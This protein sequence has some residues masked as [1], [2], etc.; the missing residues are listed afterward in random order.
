M[1]CPAR[2]HYRSSS[3]LLPS[4]AIALGMKDLVHPGALPDNVGPTRP[5]HP[6]I[7]TG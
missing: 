4:L 6:G 7:S 5:N 2:S 3:E 1:T